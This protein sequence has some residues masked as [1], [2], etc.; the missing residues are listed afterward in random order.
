MILVDTSVIIDALQGRDPKL[1]AL[2]SSLPLTICGVTTAEVLRGARD[3]VHYSKLVVALS[4]FTITDVTPNT[5]TLLSSHLYQ[6][7][8]QGITV[9]FQDVL[10]A[11]VAIEN[12]LSLW[13]RDFHFQSIQKI[14]PS[15]SLYQEPP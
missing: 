15:L 1:K 12:T 7:R 11:T 10:I 2:F 4:S 13:T 8:I 14:V 9:P 3:T 6:L 5:W